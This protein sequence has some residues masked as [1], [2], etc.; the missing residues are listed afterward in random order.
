[1]IRDVARL[2]HERTSQLV[3]CGCG[4][5]ASLSLVK[6]LGLDFYQV[7]WYD[8][9]PVPFDLDAHVHRLRLD[10][11]IVLGEFPTRGSRRP[12]AEIVRAARASG[13]AGAL[14]WSVVRKDGASDR[15]ALEAGLR[16][17]CSGLC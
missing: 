1:M 14:A 2:V 10:R 17:S 12:A 11:P 3:T 15:A 7:H 8:R 9:L 4:S 6:G 13:Y 5:A 16:S